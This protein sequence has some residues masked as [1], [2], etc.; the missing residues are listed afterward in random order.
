MRNG[1]IEWSHWLDICFEISVTNEMIWP[2]WALCY[3]LNKQWPLEWR[4]VINEMFVISGCFLDSRMYLNPTLVCKR[5]TNWHANVGRGWDV[6]CSIFAHHRS[7]TPKKSTVTFVVSA[8]HEKHEG[9]LFFSLNLK[10]PTFPMKEH[11][12]SCSC[13]LF[14]HCSFNVFY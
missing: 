6:L 7:S 5:K 11:A 12:S 9:D 8:I 3:A 14:M 2:L 4:S 10:S 1:K 13:C